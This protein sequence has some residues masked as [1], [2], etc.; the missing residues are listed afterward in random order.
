VFLSSGALTDLNVLDDN[1]YSIEN[2][3][4]GTYRLSVF[5]VNY[6]FLSLENMNIL[7]FESCFYSQEQIEITEPNQIVIDD[8]VVSMYYASNLDPN[9]YGVSC[10]DAEDGFINIS[11]SGGEGLGFEGDYTYTWTGLD[12][13]G[14]DIDLSN[15]ENN[16]DLINIPAGI[17]ELTVQDARLCDETIIVNLESPNSITFNLDQNCEA[18]P[19]VN[20]LW[21]LQPEDDP[22]FDIS[23]H[24]ANDGQITIIDAIE[25]SSIGQNPGSFSYYWTLNDTLILNVVDPEL[26]LSLLNPDMIQSNF[27]SIEPNVDNE[28]YEVPGLSGLIPGYYSLI[29]IDDLTACEQVFGPIFI[30]E[31][32]PLHSNINN[33]S[34]SDY[35]GFNL[36]CS[37]A[38]DGVISVEIEGGSGMYSVV[39]LDNLNQFVT[40]IDAQL[41]CIPTEIDLS[42]YTDID[43]DGLDIDGDGIC[44]LSCND[45][46]SESE[47]YDFD[48]D[49]DGFFEEDTS[50]SPDEFL[51]DGETPNPDYNENYGDLVFVNCNNNAIYNPDGVC[52]LNC[53]DNDYFPYHYGA[54]STVIDIENL[55]EGI[56]SLVISNSDGTCMLD[57]ISD[58]ELS[59]PPELLEGDI[60]EVND[61][62]C[63]GISDGSLLAEFSGGLPDNWNWGLYETDTQNLVLDQSGNPF[64]GVNLI[65]TGDI[66]IEYLPAGSYRLD[67]YDI[68][69]FSVNDYNYA[70]LGLAAELLVSQGVLN[71]EDL[72]FNESCFVSLFFDINEP[73]LINM[74]ND[75]IV[76]P[77]YAANDGVVTF[78]IEGDNPP[79]ELF[80]IDNLVSETISV[81]PLSSNSVSVSNLSGGDYDFYILDS[82]GCSATFNFELGW[83][84]SDDDNVPSEIIINNLDNDGDG[85]YDHIELPDCEFSYDGSIVLPEIT[86]DNDPNFSYSYFWEV[87]L[88]LDLE[89]DYMSSEESLNGLPIGMY[90]LIVTDNNYGCTI[91]YDYL[92]EPEHDCPEI[93][94]AFSPN[95]DGMNDYW[96]IGSMSDYVDAKVEVYNRWG[97]RV[98]YSPNNK[99]YWDGTYNGKSMPTADYFYII[100]NLNG[101][102]INHGRVTLRR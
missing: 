6:D 86:N 30:S 70:D 65:E 48:I 24:G 42:V 13:N 94:T 73:E 53:S 29:V 35:N 1:T 72:Y 55:S 18:S 63:F 17:Y 59:A 5:D 95:G 62:S 3:G 49:G 36:S 54:M 79:F 52:I 14:V 28:Y 101:I 47:S 98:F 102:A 7:D 11:V 89:I 33:V 27:P 22:C 84:Y 50:G 20:N 46:D 39:L 31:P 58:I 34:I 4:A 76:H 96:V 81:I 40:Q 51:E 91:V 26:D 85:V 37:D 68:N 66:Y 8:P 44:D 15:Q 16:Q 80:I 12:I 78:D 56:Y 93:P 74:I 2:L 82:N 19:S 41:E 45:S 64:V 23:C 99:E 61:A 90:S 67:I 57:T 9:G 60:I 69:G 43:G 92:L 87:D 75:N 77:C 100:K 83:G 25:P 10:Y 88:D 71:Q 32:T 38:D 97:K 21:C